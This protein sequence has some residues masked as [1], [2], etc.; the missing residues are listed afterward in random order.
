MSD[1]INYNIG[2]LNKIFKKA[3]FVYTKR[4]PI[5]NIESALDARIKQTG[6][7]DNW[8][9]FKI[10]EYNELI[11]LKPEEQV[12][13]QI[14]YINKAVSEGLKLVPNEKKLIVP[15]EDFCSD[16]N[17][18]YLELKKRLLIQGCAVDEYKGPKAFKI[19]RKC[20]ENISIKKTYDS[21]TNR[22]P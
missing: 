11:K 4:D 19:T 18:V 1:R 5:S 12:A 10:P 3:I 20:N 7:I 2:F 21:F 15:Y 17:S 22:N 8:Y 14:Y 6:S 9:S 13:G 16:P